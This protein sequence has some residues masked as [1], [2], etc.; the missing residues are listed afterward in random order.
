MEKPSLPNPSL[1]FCKTGSLDHNE[2]YHPDIHS[3]NE[4]QRIEFCKKVYPDFI[5]K[6]DGGRKKYKRNKSR[7]SKSRTSRKSRKSRKHQRKSKRHS[8]R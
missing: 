8:R 7:K 6:I 1:K 4:K 5:I 2:T 3:H